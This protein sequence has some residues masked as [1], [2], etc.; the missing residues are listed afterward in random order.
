MKQKSDS[1]FHTLHAIKGT[2]R[3]FASYVVFSYGKDKNELTI[4]LLWSTFERIFYNLQYWQFASNFRCHFFIFHL[5][6]QDALNMLI[7]QIFLESSE[8]NFLSTNLPFSEV[9]LEIL[10]IFKNGNFSKFKLS[11]LL[12]VLSALTL[13][14]WLAALL[15]KR[16]LDSSKVNNNG[17]ILLTK[18]KQT[19]RI[20]LATPPVTLIFIPF[21]KIVIPKNILLQT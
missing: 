1:P 13:P 4:W 19:A 21:L 16:K 8:Y 20:K 15:R 11:L 14:A 18:K 6:S 3:F 12:T 10:Q 17:L 7:S 9:L 5:K 2:A